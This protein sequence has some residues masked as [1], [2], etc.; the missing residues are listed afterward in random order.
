VERYLID[1]LFN[2]FV[3]LTKFSHVA[4][5]VL[6][7]SESHYIEEIYDNAKLS[8]TSVFYLIDHFAKEEVYNWL[9]Q[10][11][12]SP[13][14]IDL[15]WEYLGGNLWE[16]Q[17]ILIAARNHEN[18]EEVCN[19]FIDENCGKISEF[20]NKIMELGICDVF[21]QINQEIISKGAYKRNDEENKKAI[22]Q[23]VKLCVEKDIWFYKVVEQ[24]ITANSKS[25]W[26]AFK[27]LVEDRSNNRK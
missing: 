27:R 8:K 9:K 21:D 3:S 15:V 25:I 5:I 10:E 16:I 24:K 20:R 1:E 6:S 14:D 26:W 4:H 13:K 2:L 12:L 7:T 22:N 11:A 19:R 17:Q 18:V 23:L